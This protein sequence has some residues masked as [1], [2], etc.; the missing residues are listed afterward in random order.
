VGRQTPRILQGPDTERAVLESLR[1]A[2]EAGDEWTGETVNYRKDGTP[3]RVQ[4]S[5]APVRGEDGEI[6]YWVSVQRDVT[7]RRRRKHELRRQRNLLE[8]TQRLAGAWEVDLASGTMRWSEEVY[9]IHELD[10]NSDVDLETGIEYYAPE[11]RPKI[12]DAYEQCIE[13]REPYDLEV[14]LITAEGADFGSEPWEALSR[15]T[16]ARS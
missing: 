14:P 10:P 9:R 11:A 6:E 3:Y 2:L 5:V 12:R 8:Q 13:E 1:E 15:R 16:T 7:E 4:W